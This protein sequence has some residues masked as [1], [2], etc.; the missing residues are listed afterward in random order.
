VEQ[1]IG[2][3][4]AEE[5][6]TETPNFRASVSGLVNATTNARMLGSNGSG[7][8]LYTP[9]IELE[10]YLPLGRGFSLDFIGRIDATFYQH[11]SSQNFIDYGGAVFLDY[12]RNQTWPRFFVGIEPYYFQST[13]SGDKITSALGAKVGLDGGLAFNHNRSLFFYG[14]DY[15]HFNVSPSLDDRHQIRTIIGVSHQ[16]TAL[17]QGLAF[18]EFLYSDYYNQT[19]NNYRNAFSLS[20]SYQ[21]TPR[22]SS[23]LITSYVNNSSNVQLAVYEGFNVGLLFALQY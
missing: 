23:S 6:L 5:V 22:F 13:D 4:S 9:K 18:Y 17:L 20:L 11:F 7:D 16:F 8:V 2:T 19:R 3:I 12:R 1:D 10:Y 14:L 21:I 15:E